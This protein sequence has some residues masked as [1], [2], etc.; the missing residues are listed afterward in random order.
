MP[1]LDRTGPTG[2][3]ALSGRGLGRCAG[4]QN[5]ISA[6]RF[7]GRGR[8]ARCGA[9]FGAGRGGG[10]GGWGPGFLARPWFDATELGATERERFSDEALGERRAALAAEL[11]RMDALIAKIHSAKNSDQ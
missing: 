8:G 5:E 7:Y 2:A 4:I 6:A 3:G 1:G 9:P 11:D 10:R